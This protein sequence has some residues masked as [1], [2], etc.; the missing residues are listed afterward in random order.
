MMY[1]CNMLQ[2][3]CKLSQ[4]PTFCWLIWFHDHYIPHFHMK[5]NLITLNHWE[6]ELLLTLKIIEK[7]IPLITG[8]EHFRIFSSRIS[9][10]MPIFTFSFLIILLDIQIIV[11]SLWEHCYFTW[12]SWKSLVD[13]D[14]GIVVD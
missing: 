11:V 2:F 10:Y 12:L 3:L 8:K 6:Q 5:L 1:K 4:G 9:T 7:R 13:W 14:W